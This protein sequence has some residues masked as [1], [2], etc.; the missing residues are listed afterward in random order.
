M[1][2]EDASRGRGWAC[3]ICD[4]MTVTTHVPSKYG[5]SRHVA[6]GRVGRPPLTSRS[7]LRRYPRVVIR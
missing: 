5:K 2:R 3:R 6:K 7:L 1:I 4:R